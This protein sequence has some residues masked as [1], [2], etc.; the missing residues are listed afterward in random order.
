LK[1]KALGLFSGGLDSTLAIKVI[2]KQGIEV[3]ALNFKSPFCRCD[4]SNGCDSLIKRI[5][6]D[7]KVDFKVMYLGD[8]YLEMIKEPKHGY[9]KNLNPCID[10][11]I[12][13]FKKAKDFMK[14]TGA[15][16]LITGEVLGQ[17]P[18]SQ[19]RRALETI[20]KES[21]VE[22]LVLRPLSAKLFSPTLAERKGWVDR[23]KLFDISGRGRRPQ[24]A[25]ANELGVYE[26]SCPA[27]GCLLT[28]PTF[29]KRIR[30]MM[31][32][33]NL[34][35]KNIEVLKLGRYFRFN[36]YFWMVVAR[37]EKE[38]NKL[39][40]LAGEED[41]IFEPIDMP[42]PTALAKGRLD[43]ESKS[44]CCRIIAWYTSKDEKTRVKIKY[45]DKEEIIDIEPIEE[46]VL[47]TLRI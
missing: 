33:N 27:G 14:K 43:E 4:T 18:M 20:D 16:F 2:L 46:K 1:R 31:D 37:D 6:E 42:G 3:V 15:S 11:R 32:C 35:T 25:L 10:C 7:L 26:Y 22:D 8:E 9:G 47:N 12:L 21:G 45:Q 29:S 39:R 24:I 36:S 40:S 44:R 30:N 5:A 17:R 28:D 34:T 13:K 19:Y 41:F 23:E 38:S